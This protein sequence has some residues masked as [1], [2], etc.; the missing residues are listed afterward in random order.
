MSQQGASPPPTEAS[1][2]SHQPA[3]PR[4]RAFLVLGMFPPLPQGNGRGGSPGRGHWAAGP[5]A[6]HLVME[7]H[8]QK[9]AKKS[10][11]HTG[12]R[13][14]VGELCRCTP[15]SRTSWPRWQEPVH[16]GPIGEEETGPG[17][18]SEPLG[19]LQVYHQGTVTGWRDR[20]VLHGARRVPQSSSDILRDVSARKACSLKGFAGQADAD[21][22]AGQPLTPRETR[23]RPRSQEVK[24]S[25]G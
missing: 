14:W 15:E 16:H 23:S 11:G 4:V 7:T 10:E 1:H 21:P 3:N 20:A 2:P 8:Q 18:Q 13:V 5:F 12:H 22:W 19:T 25:Q 24:G 6:G 17:A 9:A